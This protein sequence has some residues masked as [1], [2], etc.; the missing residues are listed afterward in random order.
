[1]TKVTIESIKAYELIDSRGNP[2]VSAK[3]TLS[4]G[5]LGSAIVPSGASTGMYEAH[6]KRDNDDKRYLGKGVLKAVDIINTKISD[7]LKGCDALDFE[8]I[9][10]LMCEADGTESKSNFGANSILAVSMAS[11]RAA[12]NSL[13]MP[14]YIYFNQMSASIFGNKPKMRLPIPMMNILNGG[15]HADNPI[16]FQEFMIQPSG[17]SSFRDSLRAGIEIFHFLQRNLRELSLSTAVGD[18]GGFAPDIGSPEEALDLIYKAIKDAGYIPG[19]QIYIALD[20]ASSEF[21]E[22]SEYRLKGM[23]KKFTSEEL[24]QYLNEL[25]QNYPISSIE[26]G[27][28]ENDWEGWVNMTSVLG[29]V[30]QLVGDDIFVTNPKRLIKGI[31]KK[32]ANSILIKVNQIGTITETLKAIKLASESNFSSVISHRSGD[33][34]DSLIADFAI[35]TGVGQIKTGAPSRSERVS[36][37][38]RI[39]MIENEE[40]IDFA[41]HD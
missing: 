30:I 4:D 35:G 3:I 7:L 34:E 20:V 25:T 31:E 28:D 37:Y 1:M 26:D 29:D 41:G 32:A 15:A 6:E 8:S 21:Y 22:D 11:A 10:N 33:T 23:D 16:D 14:L 39:L 9:D 24:I 38:N 40:S 36:K 13:N 19:Q 17:F 2:T 18:E 5:N 27:L 12:S